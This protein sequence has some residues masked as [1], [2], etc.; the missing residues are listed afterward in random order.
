MSHG[1]GP[2]CAGRVMEYAEMVMD[3]GAYVPSYDI[4]A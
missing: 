2:A 1:C 4:Q 3:A